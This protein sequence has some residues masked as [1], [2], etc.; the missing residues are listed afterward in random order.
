M[1]R[2]SLFGRPSLIVPEI[3]GLRPLSTTLLLP[4]LSTPSS[5][6]QVAHRLIYQLLK[7]RR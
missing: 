1:V 3:E 2:A 5:T 7:F 6:D 4:S